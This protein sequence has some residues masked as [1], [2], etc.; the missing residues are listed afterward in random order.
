MKVEFDKLAK[1][2]KVKL[3]SFSFLFSLSFDIYIIKGIKNHK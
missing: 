3:A 2:T 1:K